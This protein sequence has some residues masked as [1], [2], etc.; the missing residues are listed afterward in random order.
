MIGTCSISFALQNS[1]TVDK[2]APRL[3]SSGL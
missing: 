1:F 2:A 3:Q